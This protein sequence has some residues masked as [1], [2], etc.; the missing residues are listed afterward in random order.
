MDPKRGAYARASALADSMLADS[1]LADSMLADSMTRR[2][3]SLQQN[4]GRD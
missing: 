4:C 2:E 1:T 3:V